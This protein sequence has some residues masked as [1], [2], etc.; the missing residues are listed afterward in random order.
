MTNLHE[1]YVAGLGLELTNPGFAVRLAAD[2]TMVFLTFIDKVVLKANI[3]CYFL[4]IFQQAISF[5]G[6]FGISQQSCSYQDGVISCSFCR[7]TVFAASGR[8]KRAAVSS[9]NYFD[10]NTDWYLFYAYGS[11][12]GGNVCNYLPYKSKNSDTQKYATS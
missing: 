6:T 4:Y 12:A 2:C 7:K 9:S 8:R 1:R 10:L 3:P 5:Q 11:A